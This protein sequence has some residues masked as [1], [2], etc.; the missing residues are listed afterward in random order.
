MTCSIQVILHH[1]VRCANLSQICVRMCLRIAFGRIGEHRQEQT[2]DQE[3]RKNR[4]H[5]HNKT[6]TFWTIRLQLKGRGC[7]IRRWGGHSWPPP[8]FY[9]ALSRLKSRLQTES[10]APQTHS[11]HLKVWRRWASCQASTSRSALVDIYL[12][13]A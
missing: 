9:A 7:R 4:T 1:S 6:P 3:N 8:R 13:N 5:Q 10:R 12:G 2:K 11:N